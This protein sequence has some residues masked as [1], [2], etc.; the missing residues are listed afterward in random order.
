MPNQFLVDGCLCGK[1][2][3]FW[4]VESLFTWITWIFPTAYKTRNNM[5]E[6]V[7]TICLGV[8]Q[9][10]DLVKFLAT[11]RHFRFHFFLVLEHPAFFQIL[12]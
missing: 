1:W 3:F 8:L 11:C 12:V 9:P 10:N 5:E 2:N 4:A 6:T 7:C